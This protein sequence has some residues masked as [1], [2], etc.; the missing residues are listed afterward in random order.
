MA[1]PTGAQQTYQSI[2]IRED[3]EDVIY[4]IAPVETPFMTMAKRVTATA[5]FHK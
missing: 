2:G 4:N 5:T 3:L 1:V